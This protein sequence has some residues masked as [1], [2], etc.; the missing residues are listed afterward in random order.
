[1][2][3]TNCLIRLKTDSLSERVQPTYNTE[4]AVET[5]LVAET[6]IKRYKPSSII[7]LL[8]K[9]IGTATMVVSIDT[10]KT[11]FANPPKD[12]EKMLRAKSIRVNRAITSTNKTASRAID[13]IYP[14][15]NNTYAIGNVNIWKPPTISWYFFIFPLALT[16]IIMVFENDSINECNNINCMKGTEKTGTYP[17]QTF[18]T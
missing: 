10:V 16:P 4:N 13:G 2:R 15:L 14:R 1:M 11:F 7:I 3:F 12:R 17:N 18:V 9:G 6:K 8:T 5:I